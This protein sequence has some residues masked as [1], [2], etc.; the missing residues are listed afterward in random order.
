MT[1]R[2][3]TSPTHDDPNRETD[4]PTGRT[5]WVK[6]RR[7]LLVTVAIL[8]VLTVLL[9]TVGSWAMSTFAAH[10]HGRLDVVIDGELLD[11][12]QPRFHDLHPQFHVHPGQG[13]RWHHHPAHLLAI[14]SFEPMTLGEALAAMDLPAS[15]TTIT[16]DAVTYDDRDPGTTVSMSVNGLPFDPEETVR[17]DLLILVEVTTDG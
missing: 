10:D 4:V 14:H 16:V 12:D 17:D 6:I 7:R 2:A 15:T 8:A 11:L 1:R 5:R 13:N 9:P 3:P